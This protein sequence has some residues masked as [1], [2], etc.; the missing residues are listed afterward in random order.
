M[1]SV[2]KVYKQ[3][4][5]CILRNCIYKCLNSKILNIRVKMNVYKADIH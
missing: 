2:L 1:N 4:M 3:W 5:I